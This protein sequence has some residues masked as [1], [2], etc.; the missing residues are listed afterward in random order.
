MYNVTVVSFSPTVESITKLV[1]KKH[2]KI[3]HKSVQWDPSCCT[4]NDKKLTTAFLYAFFW[5][6]PQ[7]LN[8]ICQSFRTLCLFHLQRQ[9]GSKLE[10]TVCSETSAHKIQTPGNY[11]QE[12]IQH[13]K[14]GKFKIKKTAFLQTTF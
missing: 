1:I 8:F 6:I 11:P 9:V 13:S 3:S 7:C 4:W 5:V 14:H 12:S 10:Q 2:H